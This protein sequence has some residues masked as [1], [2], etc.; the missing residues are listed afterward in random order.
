M[1]LKLLTTICFRYSKFVE[2]HRLN[3]W[4]EVMRFQTHLFCLVLGFFVLFDKFH[5]SCLDLGYHS[6]MQTLM[7]A[8]LVSGFILRSKH[9]RFL[10]WSR[11]SFSAPSPHIFCT[12]VRD[13][14]R[15]RVYYF[16]FSN[17]AEILNLASCQIWRR[18]YWLLSLPVEI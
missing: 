7:F 16:S 2:T 14:T 6:S 13:R 4:N 3:I 9:S 10:S 18:I 15:C 1:M 17:W 8:V 12:L 5:I 11:V